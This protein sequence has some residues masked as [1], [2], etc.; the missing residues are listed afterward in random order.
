MEALA[1]EAD[2]LSQ[3]L[4]YIRERSER[5]RQRATADGFVCFRLF[6]GAAHPHMQERPHTQ[7]AYV[8]MEVRCASKPSCTGIFK[9]ELLH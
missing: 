6:G 2:F 8:N 5:Q 1:P 4:G 9:E 7:H 3:D